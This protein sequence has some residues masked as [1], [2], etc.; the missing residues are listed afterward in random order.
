MCNWLHPF[1]KHELEKAIDWRKA[2]A[3]DT[4]NRL[5]DYSEVV[6]HEDQA[7]SDYLVLKRSVR[8]DGSNLRVS[9]TLSPE[10]EHAVQIVKVGSSIRHI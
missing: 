3:Y 7:A 6:K 4:K 9:V 1:V 8:Y 5:S 2:K 10:F